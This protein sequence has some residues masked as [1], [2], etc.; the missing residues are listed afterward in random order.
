MPD[1]PDDQWD[2]TPSGVP[3]P[4]D[5]LWRHP[6]ELGSVGGG[7]A[8][9]TGV[10]VGPG[11]LLPITP[12]TSTRGALVGAVLAGLLVSVGVIWLAQP[13]PD[14]Q[15]RSRLGGV[16]ASIV[17]QTT[18]T[19]VPVARAARPLSRPLVHPAS[20]L[21]DTTPVAVTAST[22]SVP[23]D[24]EPTVGTDAG[25]DQ[26]D[27]GS[28]GISIGDV[29]QDGDGRTDGALV[30]AVDPTGAAAA[31]GLAAGHVITAVG[32]A[33]VTSAEDLTTALSATDPGDVVVVEA[34]T[35]SNAAHTAE[36]LI[37]LG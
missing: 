35:P 30:V 17:P 18:S 23:A 19:P 16:T 31:G 2:Q 22:V 28:L 21:T 10:G 11:G 12:R 36:L 6:S 15:R 4:D 27:G 32:E 1:E 34:S 20:L 8:S 24:T 3:D 5:R 9:G 7:S 29:D 25:H 33:P 37:T 13:L 26:G 14:G